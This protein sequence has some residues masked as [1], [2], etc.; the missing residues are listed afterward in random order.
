MSRYFTNEKDEV[1]ISFDD[2]NKIRKRLTISNNI[3][4]SAVLV[5]DSRDGFFYEEL[6]KNKTDISNMLKCLATHQKCWTKI[7]LSDF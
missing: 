7:R 5:G 4:T 6:T 1:L 2:T 3:L